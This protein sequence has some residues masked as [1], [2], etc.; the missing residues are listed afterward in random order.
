MIIPFIK[1]LI[2]PYGPD[3]KGPLKMSQLRVRLLV[4]FK[5]KFC[6]F[7]VALMDGSMVR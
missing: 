6:A 5:W 2:W 7:C 4:R 1:L 3:L